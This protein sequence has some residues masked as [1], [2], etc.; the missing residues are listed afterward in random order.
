MGEEFAKEEYAGSIAVGNGIIALTSA[1]WGLPCFSLPWLHIGPVLGVPIS[2]VSPQT[3][4]SLW[5]MT[6]RVRFGRLRRARE[7]LIPLLE[8]GFR[9]LIEQVDRRGLLRLQGT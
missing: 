8:F 2:R 5:P 3:G 1:R 9:H 4:R 6:D 7:P